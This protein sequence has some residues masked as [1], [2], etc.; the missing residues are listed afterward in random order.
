MRNAK[1]FLCRKEKLIM[2]LTA[3]ERELVNIGA[4][5]ATG[6]KPCT[7]YHFRKLRE[8]GTPDVEIRQA[9]SDAMIVRD[10]A[11]E[12]MESHGLK[13]LGIARDIEDEDCVGDTTRIK[14]LVSVGAAFAVNCTT[15]LEKH[16]AAARIV[17]ITE[18][19]IRSVLDASQFIKGEA[20][21]YVGQIAQLEEK[22]IQLERLLKELQETQ[23]RLVQSEKMAALGKLVAGV[24]HEMNTPI[25]GIKSAT[26]TSTR[27]ITSILGAMEATM[28][29]GEIKGIGHLQ[30]LLKVLQDSNSV[31]SV[32]SERINQLVDSLKSF[33]RLDEAAFQK[34]CIHECLEST[35]SIMERDLKGRIRVV[36]EY[37][38]IPYITCYPGELNQVFMNILTNA[39][40]AIEG[41]GSITIRTFVED[42]N[43]HV[44][45]SDTG[46]GISPGK[47]KR[48]FEPRFSNKGA[49]VKAGLGLFISYSIVQKHQGHIK[50][51]SE[52][53]KGSTFTVIL[54]MNLAEQPEDSKPSGLDEPT[55]RCSL[56][57]T[58]EDEAADRCSPLETKETER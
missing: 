27:S 49:R 20:A 7:D 10:S 35:L 33:A 24:V 28:A 51:E 41:N 6:C 32:A 52:V 8:I 53:G 45:I 55:D 3:K 40:Q 23:A 14:E 29:S 19:E 21:H 38:D 54:P 18:D 46:I 31:A 12:I 44:H 13:H 26:D 47:I 36:K 25:A 15:N 58:K 1:S 4:S 9:I 16:I 56:L 34:A 22:N 42:G 43:V 37:G 57:E 48:L 11:R 50:V 39:A 5:V 2:S 30:G 17:G